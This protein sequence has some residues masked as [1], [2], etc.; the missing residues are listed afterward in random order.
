MRDQ[1]PGKNEDQLKQLIREK[2]LEQVGDIPVPPKYTGKDFKK[3][4]YWK[5]RGKLDVPK[6]RWVS[7]PGCGRDHDASELIAWAGWDHAQ[8]AQ[9]LAAYYLNAKQEHGWSAE[10]LLPLLAGIKDLLPWLNQWHNDPNNDYGI[11]LGDFYNG[12]LDDAC[13]E[14]DLNSEQVEAVR[15]PAS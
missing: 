7:Y 12:L 5:M 13:R 3:P 10:K 8:Q 2:Q 6:E 15:F 1:N 14:L 4:G 9:A 11:G